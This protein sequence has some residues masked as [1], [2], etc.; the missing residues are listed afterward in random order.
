MRAVLGRMCEVKFVMVDQVIDRSSFGQRDSQKSILITGVA[1]FIGSNLAKRMLAEGYR[2]IGVDSLIAGTLENVPSAVEFI[3][4]DLSD[5]DVA[6]YLPKSCNVIMHLAGQSSGELSFKDPLRDLSCNASSTI[7]LIQYAKACGAR[8]LIFASS[9]A[10]YGDPEV[11]PV[12]EN[13]ALNPKSCYGVS[14][15]AAEKYLMVNQAD[16]PYVSMRMFNVYGPG[17][18]LSNLNQGMLS[19]FVAQA[20]TNHH[21]VVK[22]SSNRFRDFIYIDDVVEAWFRAATYKS[23]ANISFNLGTGIKSSVKEIL[24]L[25]TLYVPN[26]SWEEVTGTRGDQSGI[27]SDSKLIV[28]MLNFDCFTA[29]EVGLPKFIDWSRKKL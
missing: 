14:K 12:G 20:L 8:K 26:T 25:I 17:Q 3:E 23:V 29:L 15:L 22:G 16:L 5:R 11:L 21:V 24:D 18:D 13:A 7:N 27:Y 9:M 6:K 2:V 10:V 4:K 19:I 28:D 1:G